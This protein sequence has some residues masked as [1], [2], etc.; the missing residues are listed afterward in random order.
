MSASTDDIYPSIR[1][2]TGKHVERETAGVCKP[3]RV[4]IGREGH[5]N[6][7]EDE[8]ETW[9]FKI[10]DN[11]GIRRGIAD[12]P[13]VDSLKSDQVECERVKPKVP[14]GGGREC[15]SSELNSKVLMF[16]RS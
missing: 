2:L 15:Q 10:R 13:K 7:V 14:H 1:L 4:G 5:V 8:D 6:S 12:G 9:L 16:K 3:G 11:R